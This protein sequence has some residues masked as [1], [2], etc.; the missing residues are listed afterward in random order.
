MKARRPRYR[1]AAGEFVECPCAARQVGSCSGASLGDMCGIA[2]F[3]NRE[4]QAADR[5]IVERMT[6]TLAHRGPDGD[7]F[8]CDGP[9]ALGH[10]RLSI[11]DVAGGAQP[12]SNED[13]TVWVTYNGELYNELELRPELER[14]G[15]PLPDRLRHGEPGPSLRGRGGRFR[16]PAQ[17]HVRPGASGTQPRGRLVLARDRMGQKPLFYAELPGG[18]LAFGSEPKA[19]LLPSR[20]R[21]GR[22]IRTA[23]L[24]TSFTSTS[25]P[26]TRSGEGL[27]KLPRGH[28]LVWE[29]GTI[30]VCPVL[31]LAVPEPEARASSLRAGRP[32]VLGPLPRVGGAA[33][34]VGR[35]ARRLPLGRR[36]FLERRRG[37]LRAR[38]GRE[39]AHVL[40]RVRGPEL[41]RERA[42]PARS[43]GTWA[44]IITS[45]PSRS[46]PGLRALA[47]GRAPGST[48]RSATPR[49]CPRTC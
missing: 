15:A 4:G 23:W 26:L 34:P 16:S 48:S 38:A 11:I 29:N 37:A 39:R 41:R 30:Q 43:P 42:T 27:R 45:G 8:Y 35:A 21:P 32:A 20:R 40:D 6:A 28:V 25:R 2:G 31:G 5:A 17:R 3:V 49:S 12:M 14:E 47:R 33:P 44:P 36:R 9:V 19:I 22:S 7:G 24:A 10:R 18:G 13:G 46:T 1:R